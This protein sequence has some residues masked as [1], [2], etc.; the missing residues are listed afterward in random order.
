MA[1]GDIIMKKL[2]IIL[3]VSILFSIGCHSDSGNY[4]DPLAEF[5]YFS[6]D[7]IELV[8]DQI[9]VAGRGFA[10]LPTDAPVD[11]KAA[12]LIAIADLL[13]SQQ[14]CIPT[15]NSIVSFEILTFFN[16][17]YTNTNQDMTINVS[18]NQY[19]SYSDDFI[20]IEGVMEKVSVQFTYNPERETWLFIG[21]RGGELN[22]TPPDDIVPRDVWIKQQGAVIDG[23]TYYVAT[24]FHLAEENNGITHT[25][26]GIVTYGT[27]NNPEFK[28]AGEHVSCQSGCI[29]EGSTPIFSN[30]ITSAYEEWEDFKYYGITTIDYEISVN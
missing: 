13:L 17:I 28:M 27:S 6:R 16:N 5:R 19:V 8:N 12:Y 10:D 15:Y 14:Y 23:S 25:T 21:K 18:N 30:G 9:T 29:N 26:N 24:V 4:V 11:E 2:L 20:V 1:N 3:V 22:G 7:L